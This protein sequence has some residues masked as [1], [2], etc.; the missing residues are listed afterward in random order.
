[1]PISKSIRDRTLMLEGLNESLCLSAQHVEMMQRRC[2][3]FFDKQHKMR[4]FTPGILVML[5]D[6]K[7]LVFIGKFDA[8]WLRPYW[9]MET[10]PNNFIHLA[11]LD[12]TY[13]PTC[14]AL[15]ASVV[16]PTRCKLSYTYHAV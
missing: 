12:N 13:F 10:Y 8:L 16:K 7:Q 9:V 3:I 5:Q 2:K 14:T 11:T 6:A 15:T 4:E 1:M